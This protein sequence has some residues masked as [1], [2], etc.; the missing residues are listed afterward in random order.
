VSTESGADPVLLRHH[1]R[2]AGTWSA[3]EVKYGRHST[4]WGL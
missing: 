2:G 3:R 4:R 1:D